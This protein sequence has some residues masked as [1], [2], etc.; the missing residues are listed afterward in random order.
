[1][2][3][4]LYES[5]GQTPFKSSFFLDASLPVFASSADSTQLLKRLDESPFKNNFYL[6]KNCYWHADIV[7]Q[8]IF[9][10][11]CQI[12]SCFHT[13]RKESCGHHFPFEM[14][15]SFEPPTFCC[16][17]RQGPH[18]YGSK[19]ASEE[20]EN[21]GLG[22]RNACLYFSH[23]VTDTAEESL[24]DQTRRQETG[25]QKPTGSVGITVR[26]PTSVLLGQRVAPQLPLR[27]RSCR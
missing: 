20:N 2:P 17:H 27:E 12:G 10:S 18:S 22:M 23:T 16:S 19:A 4:P 7:S 25:F 14:S 24:K 5:V 8:C 11:S 1:M 3:L 26:R 6:R 9:E 15:S 21:E 13:G